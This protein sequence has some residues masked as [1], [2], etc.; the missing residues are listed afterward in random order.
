VEFSVK[1]KMNLLFGMQTKHISL[2][3]HLMVIWESLEENQKQIKSG[4]IHLEDKQM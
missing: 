1:V 4:I 3:A 2:I